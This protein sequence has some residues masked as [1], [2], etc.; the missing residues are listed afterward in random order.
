VIS[1]PVRRIAQAAVVTTLV[2]GAVGVAHLDKSVNLS[3]DG[4]TSTVHAFGSTVADILHKQDITIGQ[5]DVVAPAPGTAVHDGEKIVVRYGRKLTVTVDGATREYWT[6]ATTVAAALQEL[7][8]RADSAKLSASRSQ[9]LGRQGLALSVTTP[10]DVV[11]R[12]DG[13]NLSASST[14][15]TVGDLLTELH[16]TKDANDR[17][18]P[19]V[20]TALTDGLKVAVQRVSTKDVKTTL[21]VPFTTVKKSD[22]S[23]YKGQSKTIKSGSE[24]AKVVT[25]R[26]TSVDGKVETK[27]AVASKVTEQPVTRVVAV[28]TKSRPVSP[29]PVTSGGGGTSGAGINL[30]RADMWDRIAQCESGGNWSINT[31]NGY[32]GGLQFDSGSWLANGGADFAPRADLASRAEQIT[33]ANRYY[34]KAGLGPWGCAHAA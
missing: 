9:A 5:H 21:G 16:V 22:S 18:K 1:R 3:V 2:A 17:V 4:K 7:G 28:G 6:T 32:Y 30:A 11:V 12:V 14:A 19:A 20:T 33:V 10:K 25:Y 29:P 8:I 15:A 13:K 27:K 26:V 23:L 31:G 24:G 34:A